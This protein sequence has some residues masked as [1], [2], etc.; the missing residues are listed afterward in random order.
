MPELRKHNHQ[1]PKN[2][3][4]WQ[5]SGCFPNNYGTWQYSGCFT[6]NNE[7]WQ[8]S[9]YFSK[10]YGTWQY[11]G[12]FPENYGPWQLIFWLFPKKIME[13]GCFPNN[14]R[15]KHYSGCFPK[16]IGI[17]Q[18]S[19][20]FPIN[21][22]TWQYSGCFPK[23][24]E[25]WQYSDCFPRND[26]TWQYS[27]CLATKIDLADS[28]Q[29]FNVLTDIKQSNRRRLNDNSKHWIGAAKNGAENN[30]QEKKWCVI[31]T[32]SLSCWEKNVW[33]ELPKL[34]ALQSFKSKMIEHVMIFHHHQTKLNCLYFM[35]KQGTQN[36]TVKTGGEIWTD[37]CWK[38]GC[39]VQSCL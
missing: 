4:T 9:G 21:Y 12:Y 18:Y 11:F 23:N 16:K 29:L 24:N 22:G 6:K 25:T 20:C 19:G 8:Y 5:Y 14:Y 2:Y 31:S 7:T 32:C 28:R 26:T 10:N 17:L 37:Q 1:V 35:W 13:S 34:N 38:Y 39:V 15:T 30:K 3:R 36:W 27:G 33:K